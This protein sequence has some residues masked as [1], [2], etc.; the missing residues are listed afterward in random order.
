MTQFEWDEAKSAANQR[1]HGVSFDDAME[2][3]FDERSVELMDD[4]HG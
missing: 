3:F 1:K 2:V 4:R